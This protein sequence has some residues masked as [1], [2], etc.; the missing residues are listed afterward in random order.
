[1]KA[2]LQMHPKLLLKATYLFHELSETKQAACLKVNN[3]EWLFWAGK[4]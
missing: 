3:N 1:M 4:G 2:Q